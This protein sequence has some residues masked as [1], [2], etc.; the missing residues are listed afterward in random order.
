MTTSNDP[1]NLDRF[2]QAQ[3]EDYEQALSEIRGGRKRSHWI[4][5]I[6][7]QIDGLAFSSTSKFYAIKSIEEAKAYL[8]H[9]I[10]GPRLVQCAEAALAVEGRTAEQIFGSPDDLKLRSSATLFAQVLPPG[11]VF[12]RLLDRYFD[13][14]PDA[15]TL[16]RLGANAEAGRSCT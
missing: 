14:A 2:V 13:G 15:R 9:P 4:W 16:R 10:L 1:Y 6:F 7:P 3:Q 12:Q 11:S 8:A 5:Y